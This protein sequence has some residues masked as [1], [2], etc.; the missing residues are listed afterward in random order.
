MEEN[1]QEEEEVVVIEKKKTCPICGS[2]NLD[3]EGRCKFCINCGWSMC[4][5]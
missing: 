2:S 3:R 1:L 4:S 5:V